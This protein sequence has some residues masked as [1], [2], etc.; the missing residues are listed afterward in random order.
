MPK[1]GATGCLRARHSTQKEDQLTPSNLV[2]EAESFA[3]RNHEGQT[4]KGVAQEPY[5][6]HV[7]EVATLVR[8]FGGTD[9]A[10]AAAWL[11]DVVEDCD[12]TIDE[13]SER[14][15]ASVAK[16]VL[17][18]TDN[19]DLPKSARKRLQV[20]SANHKSPEACLIKWA[21]KTSN[22]RSIA[23]SPPDWT[24]ERKREYIGW[25]TSVTANL[26]SRPESA[27]EG[28]NQAKARAEA[29]LNQ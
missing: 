23:N 26:P 2:E 15:G 17:E 9:I 3:R 18:V 14:F 4:R 16:V 1:T 25:A 27:V 13:I 11:H 20:E 29:S 7:E 5:I 10:I 22:L 12:P 21:D 24:S 19:K 28:F 8:E 6:T